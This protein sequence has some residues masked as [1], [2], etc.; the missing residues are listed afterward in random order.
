METEEGFAWQCTS[1][2]ERQK[3]RAARCELQG[4]FP[5]KCFIDATW[6]SQALGKVRA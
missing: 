1:G 2:P 3:Q 6:L 5:P 4:S